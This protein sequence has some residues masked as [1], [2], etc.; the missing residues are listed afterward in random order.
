MKLKELTLELSD[1][2]HFYVLIVM[3]DVLFF[4]GNDKLSNKFP[5][6]NTVV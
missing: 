6:G 3:H 2:F 4:N 5:S 1:V